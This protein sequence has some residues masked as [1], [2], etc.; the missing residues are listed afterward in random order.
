V[1]GKPASPSPSPSSSSSPSSSC[2]H[3][4]CFL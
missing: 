2:L 3:S 4:F 1:F